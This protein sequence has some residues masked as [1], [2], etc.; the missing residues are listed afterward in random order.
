MRVFLATP[1]TAFLRPAPGGES[2]LDADLTELLSR[3]T[4]LLSEAGHSVF[5]AQREEQF[6]AALRPEHVCTPFDLLEMQR[7]DAVV[8][9]PGGS[10]GVHIELGWASALGKPVVVVRT[11]GEAPTSPLLAG[12][13]T[14]ARCETIWTVPNLLVRPQEQR[15]LCERVISAL[16]RIRVSPSRPSRI[17]FVATSFGFGPVSKA[18]AVANALRRTLPG[19]QCD[20]FGSGLDYSFAIDTDAFHRT[21]RL[22]VDDASVLGKLLPHLADYDA[23]VSVLN[24]ALVET[25]PYGEVPLYL[26]DS[27]AWMWPDLPSGAER[28]RRYFVQRYLVPD[29]RIVAWERRAPLAGV[30]PIVEVG[31]EGDDVRRE[32]MLLVNLSG[33]ANP[34]APPAFFDRYARA[35]ATSVLR[36]AGLRFERIVFA[37]GTHLHESIRSCAIGRDDVT[38]AQLPHDAF[39][40]AL[41]SAELFLTSPGITATLEAEALGVPTRFLLP[42]NYSQ[43][44]MNERYALERGERE[45]IA[46]SRFGADF[47]VEGGLPENVAVALVTDRLRRVLDERAGLLDD[48]IGAML[49]G[50]PAPACAPGAAHEPGQNTI[51]R[52]IAADLAAVPREAALAVR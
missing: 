26:V 43:A 50:T 32:R 19:V 34:F 23:V 9:I 48:M 38:V 8:A 51:A 33:C 37:A 45:A 16:A 11:A 20:L 52:S 5:C 12:L 15:K 44:L 27:L 4:A 6:G 41:R 18:V 2:R 28:V 3:V 1:F 25:W 35:I 10:Y 30:G 42:Q 40:R 47:A 7:A 31:G 29:E 21:I 14:I 46:L 17:A 24:L 36:H 39:V 22:D 49:A 13:D